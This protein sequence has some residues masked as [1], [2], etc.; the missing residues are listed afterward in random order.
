MIIT[1]L[2]KSKKGN[3]LIYADGAYLASVIP[4]VFLKSNL[5]IGSYI[6]DEIIEELSKEINLNKAKEKAFRLLS[7]RAHSK[8][9]L[10]NKITRSIGEEYAEEAT[11]KMESLGLINDR[12][13][14]F[15]YAKEL[16]SKKF[17][18]VRRVKIE[19][20][21]KG[22][23]DDIINLVLEEIN[24]NE[25]ENV[26]KVLE[27]RYFGKGNLLKEEKELRKAVSYCQRLGY[28]WSQIKRGVDSFDDK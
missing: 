3:I 13:F 9:E 14:A 23:S 25:D 6:D 22:I 18:S 24:P 12:E 20:L 15:S 16:F 28:N 11:S 10:K 7:L 26:K 27:K 17:Y 8:K 2:K 19:L 5:K 21:E 1:A 4:E